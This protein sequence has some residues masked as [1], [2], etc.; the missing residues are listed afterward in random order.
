MT[1]VSHATT[2]AMAMEAA[3]HRKDRRFS[4]FILQTALARSMDNND[5]CAALD[6]FYGTPEYAVI[7]IAD[8]LEVIA[9]RASGEDEA[10]IN[11]MISGLL[12]T[13]ARGQH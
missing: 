13:L 3:E 4:Q 11:K 10:A 8:A 9:A 5:R 6:R 12:E 1:G 2:L 7:T